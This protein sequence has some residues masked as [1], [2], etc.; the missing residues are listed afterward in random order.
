MSTEPRVEPEK[1]THSQKQI[2]LGQRLHPESPLYNMAFAFVFET[3]LRSDLF[4]EAWDRALRRTLFEDIPTQVL[5]FERRPDPEE[6]FRRWCRERCARPL[7]LDGPLVD[8]VLVGLGSKTGW[9]LNQHHL[10]TDAWSTQLIYQRVAAE[11]H[12]LAN[13]TPIDHLVF[14][15]Y[16]ATVASLP[17]RE[18]QRAKALQH[19][20]ER[21]QGK[22]VS[23]YGQKARPTGTGNAATASTRLTLELSPEQ[24]RAVNALA[25]QNGFVSLS[26]ELSRFAVFATLLQGWLYQVSGNRDLGFDAP[27]AGR[28]TPAAKNALGLFIEMFPFA[29]RMEEGDSFRSLGERCLAEAK[30]FL[31]HA[32]PGLSAPSGANA[33]NVVLNYFPAAFGS[34]AGLDPNVSWVHPG[35]ADN[36][37]ALRLQVHD[38]GGQGFYTLHFDFNAVVPERY[39]RRALE[40]FARLLNAC[41]ENPDRE[42]ARVDLRTEEER[43]AL[44]ALNATDDQPLPDKT[45]TALFEEQA[46]AHPESVALSQGTTELSFDNV[47]QQSNALASILLENGVQ[48]GDRVAIFSRRSNLAVIAILATLRVRAAYVPIEAATPQSRLQY[49]IEDSK[50]RVLLVGEGFDANDPR[51]QDLPSET[52]VYHLADVTKPRA[53]LS[54]PAPELQDLAY[55]I[56]TS[57]ST[58]QPKG[59]LIEHRGLADYITWAERQYVRG[60]TFN[61][62]LFTSLAFDLTVTSIF[63]PLIT[64]GTLEIY[65]ETDGP[66]DTAL[67]DVAQ[68]NTADFIKLTPSHLSLL[69]KIGVG[70]RLRCMVVG[71]EN[72]ATQLAVAAQEQSPGLEIY[73]EYGPTE[74]VVGCVLHRYDAATDHGVSVP[75]GTPADHVQVEILNESGVPVA[76]GVPGELWISRHGLARGYHQ[77]PELTAQLFQDG[78]YRTGDRVRMLPGKLDYLGRLDRQVKLSGFRVEPGEIEDALLSLPG[79]EQCA[80][81]ARKSHAPNTANATSVNSDETC[82][83][84]GLPSNYPGA[85]FDDEGVCHI[86]RTYESIKD[87]AQ[88]YFKTM[89]DLRQIFAESA[90]RQ[91]SESNESEYDCMMLYS[92]GKD[93]SYAL[94]RLAEMGLRI[95][96]FTLDNGFISDGAKENI[97]RITEQLGVTVEFATTPAMNAIFRDSLERFSNVCNG[98]FKT[99]YTLSVQRARELG[100][101]IIVTG[102]SRGQMFETR[103]TEEM[104]RNGRCSPEEVDAAV[105]AARKVYHRTEDEVSRSLDVRIFENDDIFEQI[106]FVDFYRYHDVGLEEL[107][108]YL[109]REVPWLR[110]DDTGRS[111]NCLINDVGIFV[112]KRERGYH[113]YALP[114][115]WDVRMGHK[116]RDEAL[117]E[118]ND[119]IDT[120]F[121]RQTLA[122]V[123]YEERPADAG[124]TTL[125]AFFVGSSDTAVDVTVEDLRQQ[126]GERLPAPLIPTHLQRLDTLP[127][128]PNGKIDTRVLLEQLVEARSERPYR[129]PEGPVEEYLVE[130][131]QEELRT[132][133]VGADDSFF[134]L[135][136]TSLAAMQ[137]MLRLC[138]EFD[139]QLPLDGLFSY[140]RL[141]ELARVAEDQLLADLEEIQS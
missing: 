50:A 35:H 9:Y 129:P 99:I 26:P 29:V 17:P 81:V 84:C 113:N 27:V 33:S 82:Q 4:Q 68:A 21:R 77:R 6:K 48:P 94:C 74:A 11:Y 137:V 37:H 51:L 121:V 66:A 20:E 103:L 15:D 12:A 2:W 36:V 47:L 71:G 106:Q 41:L 98:C 136:G 65:P 46:Q 108:S 8:S 89:D 42:I 110:P 23:L 45:V 134:E 28:P 22:S 139:L 126:L 104:F 53:E 1:L 90:Q 138:Q 49:V 18:A 95:Y 85:R 130:V 38:F 61:F 80:V 105:L 67:M 100:I 109:H 102:L 39:R 19:W 64:G 83:R 93:S 56:Y 140:P 118:L 3:E 124:Q 87:H 43:Q 101:P 125:A 97:R 59:V 127:L 55:L 73:N 24:T 96:A 16:H 120:D 117:D 128:T 78:R 119:S 123:G 116:T 122:E 133:R 58:G 131:W 14:E 141:G 60:E 70:A 40:H 107:Y 76:N 31:Q 34:F 52:V 44:Q 88:A 75:I 32:L 132:D 91:K 7:D 54:A 30:L 63:L 5:D 62:P 25:V 72:F 112:H 57:G 115:S 10:I 86:C 111:T 92:G 13:G 114:Y 135:G 79:I 69:N